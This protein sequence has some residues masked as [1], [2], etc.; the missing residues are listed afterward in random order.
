MQPMPPQNATPMPQQPPGQ[1]PPQAGGGMGG[2]P[3]G[4]PPEEYQLFQQIQQAAQQSAARNSDP[5]QKLAEQMARRNDP[6]LL[7]RVVEALK[8]AVAGELAINPP[9][10]PK[11]GP[12]VPDIW[13]P[14]RQ[15][16]GEAP[17]DMA[18]GPDGQPQ[19]GGPPPTG[20]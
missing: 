14:W 4:V 16:T 15:L 2:P 9:P 7:L 3:P 11:L 10:T 19:P 12:G 5:T 18:A 13:A 8:K 6:Q 17:Q 1:M 20:G